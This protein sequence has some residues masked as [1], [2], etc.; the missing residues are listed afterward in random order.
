MQHALRSVILAAA[1][2]WT[3]IF[4][5]GLAKAGRDVPSALNMPEGLTMLWLLGAVVAWSMPVTM[6]TVMALLVRRG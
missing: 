1:L 3:G 6:L 2:A 4:W 5:I